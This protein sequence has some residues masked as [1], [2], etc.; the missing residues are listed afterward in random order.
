[1]IGKR[2]KE[3]RIEN[4]LSQNQFGNMLSVSQDTISLWE[5]G[6][7]LPTAESIILMCEKFNVSA[8][9]LLCL[10]DY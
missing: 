9:Y 1:M 3:I 8:D 2:I 6:K 10:S 7:S 5:T 4:K